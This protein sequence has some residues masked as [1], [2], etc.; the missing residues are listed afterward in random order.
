MAT[1]SGFGTI[2]NILADR[3]FGF[4]RTDIPGP[5]I[6]FYYRSLADGLDFDAKLVD[7]RVEFSADQDP[8]AG[9]K[10]RARIVRPLSTAAPDV[11]FETG[12]ENGQ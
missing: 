9:G 5:D 3:R 6:F 11:A 4:I 10:W 2:K 8:A 7:L 1:M 12:D